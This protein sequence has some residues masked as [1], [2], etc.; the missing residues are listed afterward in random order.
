VDPTQTL[1]ISQ[2]VLSI[3]LPFPIIALIYFTQKK[4][5]MGVLTNKRITTVLSILFAMIILGL[6]VWLIMQMFS[7]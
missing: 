6:N 1:I 7:G 4:E 2:V 5:L 3:V